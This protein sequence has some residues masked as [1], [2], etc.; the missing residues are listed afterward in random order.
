MNNNKN[1]KFSSIGNFFGK[2]FSNKANKIENSIPEIKKMTVEEEGKLAL[3][4]LDN[5]FANS[6]K[7]KTQNSLKIDTIVENSLITDISPQ[8]EG[9]APKLPPRFVE[10]PN[11]DPIQDKVIHS[12]PLRY[13]DFLDSKNK[14]SEN[15]SESAPPPLPLRHNDF[16]D[17]KK[18]KSNE[19]SEST[20]PPPPL[21][22]KIQL[23]SPIQA[24]ERILEQQRKNLT[25][26]NN[27]KGPYIYR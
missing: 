27:K 6:T 14:K 13:N 4:I 18:K 1:S 26:D 23:P 10:V 11:F 20:P 5:I 3:Q 7:P 15:N 12:L 8:K 24:S 25:I 21:G 9:D 22:Q 2:I 17:S 19:D 16:L